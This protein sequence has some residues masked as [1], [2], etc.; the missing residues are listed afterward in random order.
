MFLN[1]YTYAD[2]YQRIKRKRDELMK[3]LHKKLISIALMLAI[4]ASL[5]PK[6]IAEAKKDP[7]CR[8]LC[9][10]ALKATGGSY[11]LKYSSDTA[12][13][14]GALSSSARKKVK[15]IQ[16]VCDAK[17]V[18][19]LCIMQAK[20]ASNAK[21]LLSVLKKYKKENCKSDYLSDYSDTEKKVFKN[22][23]CGR[24]GS[25]VWYIA[26]SPNKKTN[27]KGQTALKKKI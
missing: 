21:S 22:A 20:N 25:Y 26:M 2:N 24:K 13:D 1:C 19:S 12:L 17:E 11:N 14:F 5:A 27:T 7:T 16:Y 23:I 8:S 3:K 4:F 15:T 18:Y 9:G 6:T 10:E